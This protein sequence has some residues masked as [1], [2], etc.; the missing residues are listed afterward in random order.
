LK[1]LG[2][3]LSG[4]HGKGFSKRNLEM[5]RQFYLTYPIT[6]TVSAQFEK[7]IGLFEA[8]RNLLILK[9]IGKLFQLSWSHYTLLMKLDQPPK[10]TFYENL[11]LKEHWS[12]RQLDRQV[13]AM[14]YERTALSKRKQIV[15][16]KA[17]EN[18]VITRPEDE[19][20]DAYVLDFLGL[21]NEYSESD[22]EDALIKHLENFLLELGSGFAFVARQKRFVLD[23]DDYF[24]DLVLYHIPLRCYVIIELKLGKF[25]HAYASQMNLYLNWAKENLYPLAQ[26]DP[27]GIILCADKRDACA[28]YAMAGMSRVFVSKYQLQLPAPDELQRELERGRELFFQNKVHRISYANG[29]EKES[30]VKGGQG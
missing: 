24:M 26:N 22:L 13:Q 30:G 2:E 1:R 25:R 3:D 9:E 23:G 20:K 14:L 5:M 15:L 8:N 6:Q 18:Q 29:E 16:A 7:K 27:I 11:S 17:N 4:R 19:V 10:R 28:K 12:V 21:K